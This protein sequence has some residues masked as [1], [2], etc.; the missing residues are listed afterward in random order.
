MLLNGTKLKPIYQQNQLFYLI[1]E[2]HI[3]LIIMLKQLQIVNLLKKLIVLII[4]MHIEQKLKIKD[5]VLLKQVK[6]KQTLNQF[7]LDW[8]NQIIL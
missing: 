1:Q 3:S 2:E 5:I 7:V 4:L 6:M 8:Y